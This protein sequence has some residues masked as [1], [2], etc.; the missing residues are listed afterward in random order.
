MIQYSKLKRKR[1]CRLC[2]VT[3]VV[4]FII[5]VG[6][7]IG[8]FFVPPLGVIDGS[9]LTA[10]GELLAFPTLAFGMRAVELGYD[11]KLQK[12]GASVEI[13]NGKGEGEE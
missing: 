10:V 5:S 7:I 8:G 3:F 1:D 13:T 11:L 12:G 9:V 2:V 6:L 4:C